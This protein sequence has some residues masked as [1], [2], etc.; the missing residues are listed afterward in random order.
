MRSPPFTGSTND[1]AS[2]TLVPMIPNDTQQIAVEPE[3]KTSGK[4]GSGKK[5]KIPRPPNAF[6]LYRQHYHPIIKEAHPEFHNNDI[7]MISLSLSIV[8]KMLM[9]LAVTLGKQWNNEPEHVK[10][11][12]KALANEA[13]R[14]HAEDYPD[15]QYSP[16]KPSEKK[17]RILSHCSPGNDKHDVY[18]N[19]YVPLPN[20]VPEMANEVTI[21]ETEPDNAT[22]NNDSLMFV[23]TVEPP[24]QNYD[25]INVWY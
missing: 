12:F 22:P 10:A 13:K 6:I 5:A 21:T 11:H 14:K 3:N 15:Y 2:H 18:Q 20:A 4:K 16:R 7:C 8:D 17:R 23:P 1:A 25:F 9:I 19:E 24:V